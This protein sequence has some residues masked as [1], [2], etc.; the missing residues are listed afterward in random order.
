MDITDTICAPATAP[1]G[2]LCI[3]RV[4]GPSAITLTDRIFKPR[5]GK[6]LGERKGYTLIFGDIERADGSLIDEVVVSLYRAPHSYTGENAVDISCHGSPYITHEIL[7]RLVDE[8]CRPARPG[9]FT[10]RAFL[11]GKMDLSQAEAVADVIASTSRAAH[12]VALSQMRGGFSRELDAL[13]NRLLHFASLMELELD[14]S[15]HEDIEFADRSE[16]LALSD[17]IDSVITRLIHSYRAGNAIKH[18]IPVTIVGE[19]NAGKSTLLN[20]LL[21]EERAIVSDVHGTTRDIIEDTLTI[22]GVM[23]RFIDTAGLRQTAD[24]VENMGIDRTY[25]KLKQA[26]I[27]I[28]MIDSTDITTAE[29]LRTDL[30]TRVGKRPLI[31]LFNK[32]DEL[33]EANQNAITTHFNG[34]GTHQLFISARNGLHLDE[35][36]HLLSHVAALP[37]LSKN[38]IIVTNARHYEALLRAHD[39]IRRAHNGL[40]QGLSGDF[41]S[42]DIRECIHH[43]SDIAGDVTSDSILKNIFSHFC[44][45][46]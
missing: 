27:V 9:E 15:D 12:Q 1:G 5:K 39:A 19:T 13:R 28:W 31:V 2:A 3:I 45:G 14:F 25:T 6:P 38:D 16:L 43:L 4:A 42:Q 20:A 24:V 33:T 32:C 17:E 36:R 8:G 29:H 22:D 44:I 46:K 11:N 10:E 7:S 35:L 41:V 40:T 37:D 18:G 21:G 23:F 34:V 30:L 26:A